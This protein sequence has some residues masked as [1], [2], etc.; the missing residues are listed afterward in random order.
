M[1][2]VATWPAD[3]STSVESALCEKARAYRRYLPGGSESKTNPPRLSGVA[4]AC[5]AL[6]SLLSICAR[7]G[8]WG[9]AP[10]E[11][12]SVPITPPEPGLKLGGG[13]SRGTTPLERCRLVQ[14]PVRRLVSGAR[15]R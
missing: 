7:T 15:E 13:G 1:L 2:A 3:T 11:S 8:Y 10:P 5:G 9:N 14:R 6:G 12:A 4:L